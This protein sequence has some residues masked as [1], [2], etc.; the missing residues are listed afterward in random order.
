M[1]STKGVNVIA[2]LKAIFARYGI[3]EEI[4]TDNGPPFDSELVKQFW[5]DWGIR[6]NPSSP[7]YSRSNG[8]VERAV[9]TLKNSL[10]K[11]GKDGNDIYSVLLDYR[12]TSVEGL[13]SPAEILMGRKIRTLLPTKQCLLKPQYNCGNIDRSL[14]EKQSK[15][16]KYSDQHAKDLQPFVVGQEVWAKIKEDWVP[17]VIYEVDKA[18]RTYLIKTTNNVVYRRNRWF[19]RS[20]IRGPVES[21]STEEMDDFVQTNVNVTNNVINNEQPVVEERGNVEINVQP[22]I[23]KS[24]RNVVPP[25]RLIQEC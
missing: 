1:P 13:P 8:Q 19:L 17:A 4:V 24:V 15:C 14:K 3:P 25:N 9:Q 16:H 5:V 12:S 10:L 22:L 11:A 20:R 6:W 23:R 21:M 7:R 18:P 2:T